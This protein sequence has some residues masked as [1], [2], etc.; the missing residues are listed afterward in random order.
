L[1]PPV[2]V[3]DKLRERGH[4]FMFVVRSLYRPTFIKAV[5]AYNCFALLLVCF[6][7]SCDFAVISL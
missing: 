1:L 5:V 7:F 6:D 3:V 2:R 4:P